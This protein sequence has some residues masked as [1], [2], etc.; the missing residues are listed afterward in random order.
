MSLTRTEARV[1]IDTAA[2]KA[3]E[4]GMKPG[5]AVVDASG[6]LIS[7]DQVDGA[8]PNRDRMARG[9]AFAAITLGKNTHEVLDMIDTKPTRYHGLLAMFAGEIYLSGGG[10][11]LQ[12]EGETV[13]A[14][15]IAGGKD[16]TDEVMAEAAIEAWLK[17]REEIY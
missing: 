11:L 15:G 3:V 7:Y 17:V 12:V 2:Q 6:R 13:G 5:I 16:G 14:I 4:L 10:V 9:K 1:L 8:M